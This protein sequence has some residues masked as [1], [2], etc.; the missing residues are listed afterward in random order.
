MLAHDRIPPTE[1]WVHSQCHCFRGACPRWT[2]T[3]PS[4][5]SRAPHR[6]PSPERSRRQ[7]KH[8]MEAKRT[9]PHPS[10]WQGRRAPDLTPVG[11][12]GALANLAHQE[13][14][15]PADLDQ[16]VDHR[17]RPR[18]RLQRQ[19]CH[20]RQE[21]GQA[22]NAGSAQRARGVGHAG[23]P[24]GPQAVVGRNQGAA[25]DVRKT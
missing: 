1:I 16:P 3:R 6:W 23:R 21:P 22:E 12:R 5:L 20:L 18:L 2:T 17:D 9:E 7:Q 14:Q 4:E 19:K 11:R 24:Q 25:A 10:A 13:H 8:A 15:E